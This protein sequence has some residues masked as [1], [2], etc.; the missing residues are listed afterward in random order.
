MSVA[1]TPDLDA[2]LSASMESGAFSSNASLSSEEAAATASSAAGGDSSV[3]A[4]SSTPAALGPSVPAPTSTSTST[5]TPAPGVSTSLA[6]PASPS[7]TSTGDAA[8]RRPATA[9][10]L[11]VGVSVGG[12]SLALAGIGA[13]FFWRR[14]R[15][16]S[17]SG[18]SGNSGGGGKG[19]DSG[20]LARAESPPPRD[21]PDDLCPPTPGLL[22][23]GGSLHSRPSGDGDGRHGGEGGVGVE[24]A[25]VAAATQH[26]H[27]TSSL[28]QG[29]M[30][31]GHLYANSRFTPDAVA[32]HDVPRTPSAGPDRQWRSPFPVPPTKPPEIPYDGRRIPPYYGIPAAELAGYSELPG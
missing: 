1:P 29:S 28:R 32:M 30:L 14:R 2:M 22:F 20:N 13:V 21:M 26:Y 10:P 7:A 27:R 17:G 15:Q 18:G 24:G 6:A 8:A 16:R 3:G 12:V 5:S 19:N 25:A 11:A 4:D 31:N 23:R 9:V